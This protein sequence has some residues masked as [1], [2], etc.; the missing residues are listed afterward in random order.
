M[1]QDQVELVANLKKLRN[2]LDE[3]PGGTCSFEVSTRFKERHAAA[4][5]EIGAIDDA[6]TTLVEE[7]P[8]D[9]LCVMIRLFPRT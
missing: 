9:L 5:V 4:V 2:G 1:P 6:G 8:A 7:K 3:G